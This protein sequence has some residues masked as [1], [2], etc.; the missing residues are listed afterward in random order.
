MKAEVV[1]V[2]FGST[3]DKKKAQG[4]AAGRAALAPHCLLGSI[5]E[6]GLALW[7]R[8]SVEDVAEARRLKEFQR[9]HT[10]Y[11]KLAANLLSAVALATALA[12]TLI[13]SRP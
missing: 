2:R 9:V 7:H 1:S 6:L 11:D 3:E 4:R 12:L 8:S 5:G 13:E 10:R